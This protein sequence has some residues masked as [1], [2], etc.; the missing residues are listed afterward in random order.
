MSRRPL[1]TRAL[2][3][4]VSLP[5]V[6]ARRTQRPLSDM[7]ERELIQLESE[8]GR[9]L[10][11]PIPRGRRREFFNTDPR[12]WIWHEEWSDNVG[13]QQQLTTKYEV[14]DDGVWKVQPGPRYIK[15]EGVELNNFNKATTIYYERVARD[16]YKR[17]PHTGQ[18]LI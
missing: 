9:E 17:N 4:I 10:F 11:G 15:V 13:R 6:M 2:R 16:I 18:K 14:R 3:R 5:S 8:I 1:I 12:I 7:T